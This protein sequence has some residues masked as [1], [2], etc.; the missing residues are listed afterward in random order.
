M[1]RLLTVSLLA[2]PVSYRQLDIAMWRGYYERNLL[3]EKLT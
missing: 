1:P 2:I 3:Y